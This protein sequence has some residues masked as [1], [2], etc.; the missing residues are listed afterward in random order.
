MSIRVVDRNERKYRIDES[1]AT[2][3]RQQ[4]INF[5]GRQEQCKV[6]RLPIEIPIY[7]IRNGRTTT[8]QIEHVLNNR[9]VDNFFETGEEDDTVQDAQN[10]ILLRM[11]K[12]N[13]YNIHREL[14]HVRK[15]TEPLIITDYGVVVNGNRRLA[16]MRDLLQDDPT[17]YSSFA[18]VDAIVLPEDA[19][20]FDLDAI[21]VEEQLRP[22]T[23][24]PYSWIDRLL[25]IRKHNSNPSIDKSRIVD[26]YRLGDD[27]EL[28]RQLSLLGLV[29]NYLDEYLRTPGEYHRITKNEQIFNDL[30]KARNGKPQTQEFS[31]LVAYPVINQ[32]RNLDTRAYDYNTAFGKYV[33]RIMD[34]LA[35]QEQIVEDS[36][37]IGDTL[38]DTEKQED[39]IFAAFEDSGTNNI[40]SMESKRLEQV[41]KLL[42]DPDRSEEAAQKIKEAFSTIQQLEKQG[43]EGQEA[44]KSIEKAAQLLM[45]VGLSGSDRNTHAKISQLLRTLERQVKR[46]QEG[47]DLLSNKK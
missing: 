1:K 42:S 33:S 12:N 8:A 47:I 10:T 9:L 35:S 23:K 6:V 14:A 34:M 2:V 21:E 37:E 39:D 7:R 32:S 3:S 20:E 29:D 25:K 38:A 30:M 24:Q 45:A 41:R 26:M 36:E 27:K 44:L 22:E 16:A 17:S 46:L 4:L 15:Q 13:T 19:T 18:S 31:L 40:A 43:E 28:N 11:S 5:R